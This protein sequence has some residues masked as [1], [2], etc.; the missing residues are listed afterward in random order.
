MEIER[1]LNAENIG[2]EGYVIGKSG[3]LTL[4]LKKDSKFYIL[5][6]NGSHLDCLSGIDILSLDLLVGLF[7]E[8]RS[9]HR[10]KTK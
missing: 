4:I 10:I 6:E 5:D 2:D 3:A 1:T 7:N 8:W 9:C